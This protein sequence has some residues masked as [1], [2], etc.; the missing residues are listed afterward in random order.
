MS[1]WERFINWRA[2]HER[3]FCNLPNSCGVTAF[4]HLA[5]M[6][7]Q[8]ANDLGLRATQTPNTVMGGALLNHT[9]ARAMLVESNLQAWA[10][11]AGVTLGRRI[12]TYYGMRQ[13]WH[14]PSEYA[15]RTTLAVFARR[16][17]TGRYFVAVNGHVV[18][19]I[20][21]KVFGYY[22]PKS[23]VEQFVRVTLNKETV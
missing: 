2:D 1:R 23:L 7:Q 17:P 22:N 10:A 21:G 14:V 6:D 4:A 15:R 19:V 16:H 9:G 8:Q 13:S 5:E 18:A 11:L 3:V 20:D 12:R